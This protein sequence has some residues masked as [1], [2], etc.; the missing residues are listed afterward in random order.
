MDDHDGWYTD[1]NSWYK[2]DPYDGDGYG[3]G[4]NYGYKDGRGY[5]DGWGN[6]YGQGNG[7]CWGNIWG[8]GSYL[9]DLNIQDFRPERNN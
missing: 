8:S 3:N 5:G 4:D 1:C 7:C 2:D 9:M 6:G